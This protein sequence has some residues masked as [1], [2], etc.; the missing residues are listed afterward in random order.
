MSFVPDDLVSQLQARGA[1][2]CPYCQV[3][4][5]V[6][7]FAHRESD[8]FDHVQ[9]FARE[10]DRLPPEVKAAL[11]ICRAHEEEGAYN[12]TLLHNHVRGFFRQVG[13][14]DA[15]IFEAYRGY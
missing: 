7:C 2:D 5:E 13:G 10:W 8:P 15:E 3:C 11:I 9:G 14:T 6:P 4:P 12:P 1:A